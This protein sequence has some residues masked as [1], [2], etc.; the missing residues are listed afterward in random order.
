MAKRQ[1]EFQSIE[2]L[3][4]DVIKENKWLKDSNCQISMHGLRRK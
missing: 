2:D 4:K 3:M 1:N